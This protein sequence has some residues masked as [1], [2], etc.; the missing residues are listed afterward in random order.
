MQFYTRLIVPFRSQCYTSF[1]DDVFMGAILVSEV[2]QPF[3][4]IMYTAEL[5]V[6]EHSH[7]RLSVIM[8]FLDP[9]FQEMP[10]GSST[11]RFAVINGQL[12][13]YCMERLSLL[14]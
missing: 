14:G 9:I 3:T 12:G 2:E 13:V 4:N 10:G 11:H 5:I 6:H 1:S 7:L 8:R